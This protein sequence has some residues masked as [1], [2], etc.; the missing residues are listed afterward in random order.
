MVINKLFG[1]RTSTLALTSMVC[2]FF[3]ERLINVGGDALFDYNNKGVSIVKL[4][5]KYH[6]T[7]LLA[8]HNKF[9]LITFQFG[10]L[11]I[12]ETMEGN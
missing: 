8:L 6:A 11:F 4:P 5:N 12:A 1:G 9:V 3:F 2:A 7:G 10:F